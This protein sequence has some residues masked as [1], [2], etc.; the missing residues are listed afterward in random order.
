MRD[1]QPR[2]LGRVL[3]LARADRREREVAEC[4]AALP[5]LVAA[6]RDDTFGRGS[7]IEAGQ[8]LEPFD[9]SKPVSALAAP[10]GVE[11]V[12]GKRAGVLFRETE[13]TDPLL[14]LHRK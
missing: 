5:A 7:R 14:D 1:D 12:V 8:S 6:L 13:R 4:A 10:L 11:K 3:E 9:T 2:S